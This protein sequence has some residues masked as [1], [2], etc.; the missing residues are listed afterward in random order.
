[1]IPNTVATSPLS[2][3]T[4]IIALL[5]LA[6]INS[7]TQSPTGIHNSVRFVSGVHSSLLDPTASPQTTV[8]MQTQAASFFAT[9]GMAVQITNSAVIKQ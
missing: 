9:N 5:G 6:P 1:V 2:G 8:E 3:G 7:T 4:P